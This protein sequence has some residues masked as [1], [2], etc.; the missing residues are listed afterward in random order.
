MTA[1]VEHLPDDCRI[2]LSLLELLIYD[3]F[4]LVAI[5]MQPGYIWQRYNPDFN[6]HWKYPVMLLGAVSMLGVDLRMSIPLPIYTRDIQ[7]ST[8][9]PVKVA[10]S[11]CR[12][13]DRRLNADVQS[14]AG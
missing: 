7:P 11:V 4:G 2:S 1:I 14:D 6:D 13:I 8:S 10:K 5:T 12:L 9:I 3:R